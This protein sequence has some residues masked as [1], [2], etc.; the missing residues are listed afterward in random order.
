MGFYGNQFLI[1]EN[2]NNNIISIAYNEYCN[3]CSL[4]ESCT[5]DNERTILEAKIE[6]LHEIAI[7]D[8]F[9]KIKK[10][11]INFKN[12]LNK[13]IIKTK[14]KIN[15]IRRKT[16][17]EVNE[18]KEEKVNEPKEEKIDIEYYYFDSV[19]S[20]MIR[21]INLDRFSAYNKYE[22][23]QSGADVLD[24]IINSLHEDEKKENLKNNFKDSRNVN[25]DSLNNDA[26]MEF[27]EYLES[28]PID[29]IQLKKETNK[30]DILK[31]NIKNSIK[32]FIE[33]NKSFESDLETIKI[34]I[35]IFE[36]GLKNTE[37]K[38]KNAESDKDKS[39][40]L[41]NLNK[42]IFIINQDI[43]RF[44]TILNKHMQNMV[45]VTKFINY[46]KNILNNL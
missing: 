7:K 2:I 30:K 43:R 22:S 33:I 29:K 28:D 17:K 11:W 26:E 3:Y 25:Y 1:R 37:R 41:N 5:N 12:W 35:N 18:P 32:N 4:L 36:Y 21:T 15:E 6:V 40:N 10:I 34:N 9:E 16:T 20:V 23:I 39:I 14:E 19:T 44:Q 46:N 8:I 27:K 45:T 31:N 13:L 38:I 24:D 42:L